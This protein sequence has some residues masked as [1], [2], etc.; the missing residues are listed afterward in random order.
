MVRDKF[1]HSYEEPLKRMAD[2]LLEETLII[3]ALKSCG[4]ASQRD[5]ST[6]NAARTAA[7]PEWNGEFPWNFRKRMTCS[8]THVA[9]FDSGNTCLVF[10]KAN[11]VSF[12]K[13]FRSR[14]PTYELKRVAPV[15]SLETQSGLK[16]RLHW[17]GRTSSRLCSPPCHTCGLSTAEQSKSPSTL[18]NCLAS[19]QG[20]MWRSLQAMWYSNCVQKTCLWVIAKI[21]NL[22]NI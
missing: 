13:R 19:T 8:G 6:A 18:V 10:I 20:A 7:N 16:L 11:C 4:G 2:R 3:N 1:L 12:D 15:G 17:R 22:Q 5:E 21:L 9:D 14:P